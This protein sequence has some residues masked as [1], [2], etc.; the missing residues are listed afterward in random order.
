MQ[1][2]AQLREL[3]Q[4]REGIADGSVWPPASMSFEL[5]FIWLCGQVQMEY[6]AFRKYGCWDEGKIAKHL[7]S[8]LMARFATVHESL[9]PW[10]LQFGLGDKEEAL[11]KAGMEMTEDLA[12]WL[13]HRILEGA[14]KEATWDDEVAEDERRAAR[15]KLKSGL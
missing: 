9:V 11:V 6:R 5:E 2:L 8:H 15:C 4:L 3:G 14:C 7:T 10:I 13:A 1:H 12:D